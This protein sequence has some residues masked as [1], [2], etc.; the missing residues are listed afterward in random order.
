MNDLKDEPNVEVSISPY[1]RWVMRLFFNLAAKG[2]TD[3]V[4][5]PHP[6]LS[7]VR[8]RQAIRMAIDVDTISKQIFL[9]YGTAGLDR[10][11]PPALRLRHPHGRSLIQQDAAALLEAGR[12]ERSGRRW[13]PRMPRLPNAEEGTPMEMEFITYAEYGEPLDLT[14]QFIAEK[15]GKIGIKL[16]LTRGR[17]QRAVGRSDRWRHRTERQFRP[18]P[19]G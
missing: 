5:S 18:G 8:V 7:D 16:N 12:L 19:V 4:A 9:G 13:H 15:L 6:I 10:V 2:T 14:Q 11:L 3:P 1:P 17:R